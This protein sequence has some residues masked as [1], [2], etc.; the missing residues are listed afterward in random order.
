[1][2]F[3][4]SCCVALVATLNLFADI[5]AVPPADRVDKTWWAKRPASVKAKAAKVGPR[6]ILAAPK[7]KLPIEITK[8][9]WVGRLGVKA[10]FETVSRGPFSDYCDRLRKGTAER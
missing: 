6:Y 10:V 4:I 2:K 9:M 8:E 3:P 7:A 1:M 5:P